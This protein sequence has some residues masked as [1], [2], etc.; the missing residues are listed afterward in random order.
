MSGGRTP[1][2]ALARTFAFTQNK[3]SSFRPE[4]AH[5]LIVSSA[6]EKS[7]SPPRPS[8]GPESGHAISPQVYNR[9]RPRGKTN[10]PD[11]T[12]ASLLRDD[13]LC[14][15]RTVPGPSVVPHAARTPACPDPADGR[16][17]KSRTI[18]FAHNDVDRNRSFGERNCCALAHASCRSHPLRSED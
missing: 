5:S 11:G 10:G 15:D 6:V 17:S 1:A 9:R 2:F 7:A 13:H 8:P 18:V 16:I 12:E 3:E 4:A 14:R